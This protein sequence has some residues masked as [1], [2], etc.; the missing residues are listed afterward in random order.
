ME[1]AALDGTTKLVDA[2]LLLEEGAT[3]DG[4]A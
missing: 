3:L 1:D 2:A 4:I